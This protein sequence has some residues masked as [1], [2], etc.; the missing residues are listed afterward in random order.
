MVNEAESVVLLD[1]MTF[2]VHITSW[3][4]IHQVVVFSDS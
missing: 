3:E 2:L 4:S 1:L